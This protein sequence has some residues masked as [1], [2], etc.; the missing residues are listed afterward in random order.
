MLFAS[1]Q[2]AVYLRYEVLD[3]L[4]SIDAMSRPYLLT[5]FAYGLAVVL[6]YSYLGLYKPHR[7]KAV[8]GEWAK[9]GMVNAVGVLGVMAS[10]YVI[11]QM[12]FP[13]LAMFLFWLCS[14]V[15]VVAKRCVLHT[16]VR[17]YRK[18]GY[19]QKHIVLMGS[20]ALAR[21]YVRNI[22]QNPEMG[23]TIDGYLGEGDA[24]DLGERLGGY[25]DV[26]TILGSRGADELIIALE[27]DE[28]AYMR[29]AL[30]ASDKEGVRAS[31]I[32]FYNAYIP[33]KPSIEVIGDMKLI[34]LWNTPLDN[35]FWAAIKRGMDIVGSLLFIVVC[36]PLMLAV[37]LG[38]KLSSPGPV[39]FKQ[40]RV[41]KNKKPFI[42]LKFRSMRPGK[43][44]D[45]AWT[46]D[47]DPRK[48]R[49]GSFIRKF[50]LDETP[51]FF[52][53]LKG[54][55]SLVG[56]RPEIPYHVHH[57]KEEIPLYLIR[58]QVRPGITGLAQVNGLRGNTSIRERVKY[59][60][61]YI[62]NWSLG[63]DVRIL[64]RTLFG[65]MINREK[66]GGAPPR[67]EG[68]V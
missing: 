67:E 63:L 65:G 16:L 33:I 60:L 19:N 6:A 28:M 58:Q 2:L 17:C 37:A 15:S 52:N 31:V 34:N 22:R 57:F 38:V 7:T 20:G 50:S 1:F 48:T 8:G 54:D 14:T 39:L 44:E 18:H 23:Y 9:I 49:F 25:E 36:S 27:P 26:E 41:G 47:T 10:M 5:A 29:R 53:V 43:E 51:Q 42:M 40:Q 62:E 13:R 61:W 24:S 68:H 32:P 35:P 46:T 12:E 11:R 55:M 21:D 66:M 59:D 45:T 64:L 30:A 3:G 56:P 4:R